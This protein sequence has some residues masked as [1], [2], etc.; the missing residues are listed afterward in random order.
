MSLGAVKSYEL[1]NTMP[2][3]IEEIASLHEK[4][5]QIRTKFQNI[6]SMY[7]ESDYVTRW[8]GNREENH[9]RNKWNMSYQQFITYQLNSSLD[10]NKYDLY[11]RLRSR[12]AEN[13]DQFNPEQYPFQ[14]KTAEQLDTLYNQLAEQ[15]PRLEQLIAERE[16]Q[17]RLQI[18]RENEAKTA[19]AQ[20]LYLKRYDKLK[21]FNY[22]NGSEYC[23]VVPK[24]LVSLIVEGQT[25]HHCV[26]SFVDSVSEGKDTIVFLRKV[27]DIDTP[28]VT[29]SLQPSDKSWYIDQAHGDRNSNISD[30]DVAFLKEWAEEKGIILSSVKKEYGLACHR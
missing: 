26:G 18:Q 12:F 22:K 30:E 1:V 20:E 21:F 29:I 16:R 14:I 5:A 11:I 9:A 23:I 2:N 15:E 13:D 10:L 19:K 7:W 3:S 27:N 28:Y 8:H 25:L 24:N 4:V 17:R 6:Y